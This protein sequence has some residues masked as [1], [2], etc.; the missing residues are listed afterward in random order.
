MEGWRDTVGR[1]APCCKAGPRGEGTNSR[2]LPLDPA[3]CPVPRTSA[4]WSPFYGY[5]STWRPAFW[6]YPAQSG[7]WLSLWAHVWLPLNHCALCIPITSCQSPAS[8]L[9]AREMLCACPVTGKPANVPPVW[10]AGSTFCSVVWSLASGKGPF[11]L[12]FPLVFSLS[13]WVWCR[14]FFGVCCSHYFIRV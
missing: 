9:Y 4:W 13:P 8:F 14:G 6:R 2:A 11:Q 3:P 10:E 5:F 1:W 12:V 7:T